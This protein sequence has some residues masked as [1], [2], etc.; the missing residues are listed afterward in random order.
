[1]SLSRAQCSQARMC[2][3]SSAWREGRGQKKYLREH[4]AHTGSIPRCGAF[5]QPDGCRLV[6]LLDDLT[7]ILIDSELIRQALGLK[8]LRRSGQGLCNCHFDIRHGRV[9]GC[10][11]WSRLD[12]ML[13]YSTYL[14]PRVRLASHYCQILGKSTRHIHLFAARSPPAVLFG[15]GVQ[16]LEGSHEVLQQ[17]TGTGGIQNSLKL[18]AAPAVSCYWMSV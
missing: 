2:N 9:V 10:E 8:Q 1:M 12:F 7:E 3:G 16:G 15:D 4:H 17:T 14:A 18:P 11:G 13:Q 6:V 5:Q